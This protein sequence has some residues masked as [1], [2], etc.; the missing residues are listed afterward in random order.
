VK[1]GA[2]TK[3][4]LSALAAAQTAQRTSNFTEDVTSKI[5]R[6]PNSPSYSLEA[7]ERAN[8]ADS[9]Q[10]PRDGK[11]DGGLT[12]PISLLLSDCI[13]YSDVAAVVAATEQSKASLASV[14][15]VSTRPAPHPSFG[16]AAENHAAGIA[17]F[18][19]QPTP[20]HSHCDGQANVPLDAVPTT[21]LPLPLTLVLL[22]RLSF[23]IV[24][25]RRWFLPPDMHIVL[26]NP[27]VR[28]LPWCRRPRRHP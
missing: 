15:S 16:G 24:G 27:L 26:S 12:P 23:H 3:E 5:S 14:L 6:P 17:H 4:L 7:W 13:P 22:A 28:S 19:L 9:F 8:L 18:A 1:C 20:G 2:N 11:N 10:D 21:P 25:K